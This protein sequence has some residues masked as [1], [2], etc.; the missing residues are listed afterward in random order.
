MTWENFL[1]GIKTINAAMG[2][3]MKVDDAELIWDLVSFIPDNAWPDVTKLCIE[4]W[5]SYPRNMVMAIK[6]IWYAYQGDHNA[7]EDT[8]KTECDYCHDDTGIIFVESLTPNE[9]GYLDRGVV[10]CGHC[11]NWTGSM[12]EKTQRLKLKEIREKGYRSIQ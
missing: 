5:D 3:K 10:R 1:Q 8:H 2:R 11:R 4:R 7:H 12:S 9:D 6:E